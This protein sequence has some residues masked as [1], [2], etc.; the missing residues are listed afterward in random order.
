[1]MKLFELVA[2]SLAKSAIY[3]ERRNLFYTSDLITSTSS[4]SAQSIFPG[5][6]FF[7][8]L[9]AYFF[10]FLFS[11]LLMEN[12]LSISLASTLIALLPLMLNYR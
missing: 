6:S 8:F 2:T 5:E 12:S 3:F 7:F 11:F 4:S 10:S 9:A 1:M